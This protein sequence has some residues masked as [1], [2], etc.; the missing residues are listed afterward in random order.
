MSTDTRKTEIG[1]PQWSL[2]AQLLYLI[3]VNDL[4]NC[5]LQDCLP[6]MFADDTTLLVSG[7][8]YIETFKSANQNLQKLYE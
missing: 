6:V 3:Y 5:F 1:A 2:L 4:P 8:N 7:N